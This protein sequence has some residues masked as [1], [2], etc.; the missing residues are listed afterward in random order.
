M[1]S[2]LD[3]YVPYNEVSDE[4]MESYL[5]DVDSVSMEDKECRKK[6]VVHLMQVNILPVT[7]QNKLELD[8]E[9]TKSDFVNIMIS[10]LDAIKVYSPIEGA[11]GCIPCQKEKIMGERNE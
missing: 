9:M 4:T 3:V 6:K 10:L 8:R 11:N 5:E 2:V 7:Y 1:S